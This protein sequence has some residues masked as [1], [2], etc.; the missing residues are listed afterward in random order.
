M[1][2]SRAAALSLF[3]LPASVFAATHVVTP[4]YDGRLT[5]D[6]VCGSRVGDSSRLNEEF[7]EIKVFQDPLDEDESIVSKEVVL[8]AYTALPGELTV[9]LNGEVIAFRSMK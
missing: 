4:D 1:F 5:S 3:A 6:N 2:L 8:W 7:N 9:M